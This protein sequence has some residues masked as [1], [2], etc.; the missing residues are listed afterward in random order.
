MDEFK[1]QE[2]QQIAQQLVPLYT[3]LRANETL[4]KM[5]RKQYS[6]APSTAGHD[7]ILQLEQERDD[8]LKSIK[9]LEKQMRTL[10]IEKLNF[11]AGK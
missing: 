6:T 8:Y 3:S 5:L 1:S 11:T 7:N 10:E 4:L 2:A 9:T